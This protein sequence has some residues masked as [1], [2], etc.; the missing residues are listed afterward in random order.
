MTSIREAIRR[1]FSSAEPLPA[2][3][4]HYQT[5]PNAAEQYRLH[6]RLEP[7]GSGL[8]IVNAK[9]V[10]HLNQSAAEYAYYLI[11]GIPVEDAGRKMASR[12]HVTLEQAQKDFLD[13]KERIETMISTPDLDPVTYLGFDR[14]EPYATELSAPYRLD[15]AVT[16]RQGDG[17]LPGAIPVERVKR[18]LLTQ[19]WFTIMD[20]A[21]AAGIPQ[22]I[23]TG[24][25]PTLRP[26]LPELVAHAESNGQVSGLLTNGFRLAETGY[27]H[28]LLASGLD[29]VMIVLNPKEEQAWEAVR[30]VAPEDLF[31]TVHITLTPENVS[32]VPPLIDRLA[33]M[34]VNS[35]S[36]S[37]SDAS[38]SEALAQAR[39][40]A[41]ER[42][43]ALVWDLPVPYSSLNP[44]AMEK[45]ESMAEGAGRAW[46]YVEPDGDVLPAQGINEV[47]GN[48]L[49]DAWGGIWDKAQAHW[50]EQGANK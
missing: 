48:L 26:D 43:L 32:D 7:D 1:L 4:H 24:G 19:E 15:C 8:L 41:A 35:I 18:E 38:L 40:Y 10:L 27:F 22:L 34:G 3:T 31:M 23:F 9:T 33:S 30:D 36:L 47:L 25:E 50:S 16:Y 11:Q 49:T 45:T 6:L 17:E 28:Q 14:R 46:L 29:H 2:G 20:K 5:P 44:I 21:W 37:A 12:Y 42:S 13:L 39:Q